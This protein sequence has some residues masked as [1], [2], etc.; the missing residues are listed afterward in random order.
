MILAFATCGGNFIGARAARSYN[1][2]MIIFIAFRE[3]ER[4]RERENYAFR[5]DYLLFLAIINLFITIYKFSIK[6][7]SLKICSN[8]LFKT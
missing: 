4:E 6:S 5:G 8:Y 7:V 1:I 2:Q 3:R